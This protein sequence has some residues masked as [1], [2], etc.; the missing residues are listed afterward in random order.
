MASSLIP[1]LSCLV[2][3]IKPCTSLQM[4]HY[5]GNTNATVQP[6]IPRARPTLHPAMQQCKYATAV[7]TIPT[8][9]HRISCSQYQLAIATTTPMQRPLAMQQCSNAN[10]TMQQHECYIVN[11]IAHPAPRVGPTLQLPQHK[12]TKLHL[13]PTTKESNHQQGIQPSQQTFTF[14]S[15]HS[16]AVR[17]V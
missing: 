3:D 15:F 14:Y 10:T 17:V 9:Q 2:V 4:C 12:S 11:T 8:C 7:A 6:L 5:Q 13:W 16:S 1:D